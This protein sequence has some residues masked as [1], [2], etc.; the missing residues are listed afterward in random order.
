M[1]GKKRFEPL[2]LPDWSTQNLIC[3]LNYLYFKPDHQ[4]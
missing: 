1:K 2:H 4:V 3:I